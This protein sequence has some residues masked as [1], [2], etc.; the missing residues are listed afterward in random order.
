MKILK[1]L[2][3]NQEIIVVF[4]LKFDLTKGTF[5]ERDYTS[6]IRHLR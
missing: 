1:F 3:V 4:E 2:A 5:Y 6:I